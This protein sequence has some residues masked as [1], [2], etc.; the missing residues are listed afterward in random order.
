M[1]ILAGYT[2][3]W[4]VSLVNSRKRK[5]PGFHSKQI[6]DSLFW[7]Q[8]R[9]QL[10]I[11]PHACIR[12]IVV[13]PMV[14]SNTNNYTDAIGN[15]NRSRRNIIIIDS[16]YCSSPH[17][18]SHYV[19]PMR[20]NMWVEWG[21]SHRRRR[22][23]SPTI[24]QRANEWSG[25]DAP[26]FHVGCTYWMNNNNIHTEWRNFRGPSFRLIR[27]VFLLVSRWPPEI[28]AD[29]RTIRKRR[30][31]WSRSGLVRLSDWLTGVSCVR[32]EHDAAAG[33]DW[34][35][36]KEEG[37]FVDLQCC[38]FV[39]AVLMACCVHLQLYS[40]KK[41]KPLVFAMMIY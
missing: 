33:G 18:T 22:C 27:T 20:K 9:P 12:Y 1:G 39:S 34:P 6:N 35:Y 3:P 15:H 31:R 37:R 10:Y 41:C 24:N 36:A 28:S 38:C 7:F 21:L 13:F 16:I 2:W 14:I 25:D 19:A 30:R 17:L 11:E 40:L 26:P 23:R 29:T 32:G 8:T 5:V 4:D